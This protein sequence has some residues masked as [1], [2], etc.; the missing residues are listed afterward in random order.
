MLVPFFWMVS[1]SLMDELEVYRF[2]PPL[3]PETPRWENY[4]APF[5]L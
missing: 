4:P 1:T 3:L 2:P 5:Q